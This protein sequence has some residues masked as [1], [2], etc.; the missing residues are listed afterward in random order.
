MSPASTSLRNS[1][2]NSTALTLPPRAQPSDLGDQTRHV[3]PSV[4]DKVVVLD[5]RHD[6]L[7]E[8]VEVRTSVVESA[9]PDEVRAAGVVAS[10]DEC[11]PRTWS[12]ARCPAFDLR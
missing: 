4:G 3:L 9:G 10:L 1:R 8:E 12:R 7:V 5:R 6:V 2:L 11:L